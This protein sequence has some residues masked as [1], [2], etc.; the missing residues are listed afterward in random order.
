[1]LATAAAASV[2]FFGASRARAA[3]DAGA[4]ER[5]SAEALS[6]L[7]RLDPRA[8]SLGHKSVATLIFPKIVKAGFIF[9]AEGGK[10]ELI[11]NGMPR[12]FYTIGAASFGLQAGVAWFSY[13]AFFMNH[14]SLR[15]LNQSDG[16]SIGSDPNVAVIDRGAGAEVTSTTLAKSVIAF[17]FGQNGLMAD[18]SLQGA[19]ISSYN[20]D[21]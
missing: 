20:P 11:A 19:K 13:V 17:P 15:Y 21:A 8:S 14:D 2:A 7:Y 10:G 5:D 1:M 9:G 3:S 6:R 18:L 4:I 12:R 16:W